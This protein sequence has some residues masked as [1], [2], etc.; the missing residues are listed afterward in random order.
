V[1]LDEETLSHIAQ[2]TDA[3]Y[4]RA[5][6]DTDLSNIYEN[7]STQLVFKPQQTELTAWFTG[8]A[9]VLLLVAG[10]LSMLWFHRLA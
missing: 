2:Q 1:R 7:L 5:E 10:I 4:F 8:F 6:S 3:Q 9:A